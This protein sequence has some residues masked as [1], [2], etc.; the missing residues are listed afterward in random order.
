MLQMKFKDF[1]QQFYILDNA[2][3]VYLR[4]HGDYFHLYFTLQCSYTRWAVL[5]VVREKIQE[6]S[7]RMILGNKLSF[8]QLYYN[9]WLFSHYLLKNFGIYVLVGIVCQKFLLICLLWLVCDRLYKAFVYNM[10]GIK[11]WVRMFSC[12]YLY[13]E[14]H[15]ILMVSCNETRPTAYFFIVINGRINHLFL[16]KK[17]KHLFVLCD[18]MTLV[19]FRLSE[20]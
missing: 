12:D 8:D 15:C 17:Q 6:V 10:I 4:T 20:K 3:V 2:H 11:I 19:D 9:N 13:L 7:C 14:H 1:K 18:I 5:C 16:K